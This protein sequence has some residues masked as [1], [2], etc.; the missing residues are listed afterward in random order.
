MKETIDGEGMVFVAGALWH[1]VADEKIDIGEKVRIL[2]GEQTTLK[3]T[4]LNSH[5]EG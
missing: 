1:A 3:V 5:K 2:S 4:R